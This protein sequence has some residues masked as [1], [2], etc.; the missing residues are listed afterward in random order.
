VTEEYIKKMSEIFQELAVITEP[1]SEEDQVVHLLA[2]L[3][4]SY[5]VLVTALESGSDNV[6]PLE[7]VTER[8]LR[9]EQKMSEKEDTSRS[10]LMANASFRK[11]QFSCHF[12]KKVGHFKEDCK[13][14]AQRLEEE[15]INK[16]KQP[17]RVIFH[18]QELPSRW[19]PVSPR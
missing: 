14:Y 11:K 3:P 17:S 18:H 16:H 19:I 15:E 12:S 10:V 6:P 4:D 8:L 2:G 9:E 1:I 13:K 5:D 7:T